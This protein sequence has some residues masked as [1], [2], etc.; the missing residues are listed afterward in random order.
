MGNCRKDIDAFTD[1]A[2]TYESGRIVAIGLVTE[3]KAALADATPS[4]WS[5]AS[6]W[7]TETYSGD[8]LI[9][10]EVSG[11]YAASPTTIPG[12]GTQQERNSGLT[13]TATVRIESVKGN[14][15]YMDDLM[16]SQNYRLAF[17]GDLYNTLFVSTT[18]V[19]I[20]P[21]MLLEEGLDTINEWQVEFVWSDIRQPESYDV[22]T[23][24]FQ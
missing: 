23:G 1:L 3:E 14:N 19:R 15:T 13:H 21:T 5:D 8:I 11:S 9:H 16:L 22:P 7:E 18:N 2:C 20:T 24:I 12:K 10:Q 6:F 17:V 4:L